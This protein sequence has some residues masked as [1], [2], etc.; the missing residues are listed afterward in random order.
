MLAQH[1]L[2][3]KPLTVGVLIAVVAFALALSAC[4]G[5]SSSSSSES[6]STTEAESS[7]SGEKEEVAAG[8]GGGELSETVTFAALEGPL[9]QGGPAFNIG[10]ELE[11]KRLNAEGG[12]GGQ[13]VKFEPIKTGGTPEGAISAYKQAVA[14]QSVLGTFLGASGGSA[15]KPFTEREGLAL[16]AADAT[17]ELIQP[18]SP[19]AFLGSYDKEYGASGIAWAVEKDHAK[20]I[21]LIHYDT[22]FS[23]QIPEAAQEACEDLGCEIVDEE[24][25]T[26]TASIEELTPQ[27]TKMKSSGAEAYYIEG[28]NPNAFKAAR[29]LGMFDKPVVSE[30]WLV[31]PPVAAACGSACEGVVFAGLKCRL[32]PDQLQKSDP[33]RQVCEEYKKEY[34]KY[35][36]GEPFEIYSVY[37]ADAVKVYAAV[38][39]HLLEAGEEV[40]RESIAQGMENIDGYVTT[41]QGKVE[42]TPEDHRLLGPFEGSQISMEIKVNGEE[43]TYEVAKGANPMG[44]APGISETTE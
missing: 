38:I 21:A 33:Q 8:G 28:L 36:P 26:T 41:T 27:L 29:Q 24:A 2:G 23:E 35:L 1:S 31:S 18:L 30:N 5:G 16:I 40:T 4:G 37:G 32:E 44:A 25:S 14:N 10:M 15:V 39:D 11:V 9:A 6:S 13:E 17:T 42:T 22:D 20:K 7:G 34:E 43:V 19:Y 12:I 3:R